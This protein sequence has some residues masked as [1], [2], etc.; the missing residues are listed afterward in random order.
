MG[1]VLPTVKIVDPN[2]GTDFVIINESDY[3][4]DA[5]ELYVEPK[6][7]KDEGDGL[8][9]MNKAALEEM[10]PTVGLT[11]EGIEGTGSKGVVKNSDMVDAIRAAVAEKAAEEAE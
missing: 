4:P 8:D 3:D 5:H 9:S 6:S 2:S 1:K 10:L 11:K 7:K